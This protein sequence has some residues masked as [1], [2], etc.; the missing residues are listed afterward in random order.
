MSDIPVRA[1]AERGLFGV[2][3]IDGNGSIAEHVGGWHH[4]LAQAEQHLARVTE[5][6]DQAYTILSSE[7]FDTRISAQHTA[8]ISFKTGHDLLMEKFDAW[9]KT[10]GL[11]RSAKAAVLLGLSDKEFKSVIKQGLFKGQR[12]PG[13]DNL[14]GYPKD[15]SLTKDQQQQIANEFT[16][17]AHQ[18][19]AELGIT[20]KEFNEMKRQLDLTHSD[21]ILGRTVSNESISALLYCRADITKLR[22]AT[23]QLMDKRA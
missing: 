21:E 13:H 11:V 12:M 22:S 2:F 6:R 10:N 18:M 5:Q 8:K 19:A 9:L 3:P 15:L 20:D 16:F 14:V 23:H 7:E 4:T 17:S 1:K